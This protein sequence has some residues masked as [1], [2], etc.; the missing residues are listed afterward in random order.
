VRSLIIMLLLD[1]VLFAVA[2][3]VILFAAAGI[4]LMLYG[5]PN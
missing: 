4:Q 1:F 3:A 5:A 2:G